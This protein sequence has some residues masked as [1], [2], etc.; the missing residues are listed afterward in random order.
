M[1]EQHDGNAGVGRTD[2]L[3]ELRD[4]GDRGT[5]TARA[6]FAQ[7][8]QVATG[9]LSTC[10]PVATTVNG[11]HRHTRARECCRNVGVAASVLAQTVHNQHN[12]A[13]SIHRVRVEE[14]LDALRVDEA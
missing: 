14:N 1:T 12:C 10:A 3:G 4:V 6:E 7:L 5:Q 9:L 8:S 11:V 2:E 13:R